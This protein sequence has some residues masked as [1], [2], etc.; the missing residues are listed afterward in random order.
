MRPMSSA[1]PAEPDR[2]R[3]GRRRDPQIEPRALQAAMEVYASSGWRGFSF[4]SV[5]KASGIG[6]PAIYR[7]WAD[8]ADL[9]V[10]AFESVDFPIAG[11]HGSLEADLR[12]YADAWV[13]WFQAPHLPQAGTLILADSSSHP[14]LNG[15]YQAR[16]MGPRVAAVRAITTRAIARG[17]LP[18][19]TPV[20][21]IP[22]L[23]LG[24][25]FMHW[26]FAGEHD[27]GFRAGLPAFAERTISA[28]LTGISERSEWT[29]RNA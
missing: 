6:K 14:E 2:A 9:L 23:L 11:D 12:T 21:T 16:V 17:E 13:R 29:S 15:P 1:D 24:A 28:I 18:D 27:D 3:S 20:T 7:R 26:S 19:D 4:E 22:E 25:F 5:A 8:R 10:S